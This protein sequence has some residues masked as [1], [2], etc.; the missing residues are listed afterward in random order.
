[1]A[2]V[3]PTELSVFDDMLREI[4]SHLKWLLRH[5]PLI[6]RE[7][8]TEDFSQ[9]LAL[10]YFK[11]IINIAHTLKNDDHRLNLLRK[12]ASQIAND[13][14]KEMQRKK[15][16]IRKMSN[17][18]VNF[19][20]DGS[21]ETFETMCNQERINK[22]R[23]RM[24]TDIW[25]VIELRSQGKSWEACANDIGYCSPSALRLKVKR[26]VEAIRHCVEV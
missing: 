13:K 20:E 2:S 22:V 7:W 9:E 1:M 3:S 21:C 8:D 11:N 19:L 26:N 23:S 12:M 14:L 5:K 4:N 25:R 15:R 6:R 10:K 18:E 16:D 17:E 24:D